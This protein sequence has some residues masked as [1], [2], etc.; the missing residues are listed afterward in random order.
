MKNKIFLLY[1][2]FI[3][4][5]SIGQYTIQG[6]IINASERSP[7]PY[8]NIGIPELGTGTVSGADGNFQLEAPSQKNQVRISAIGF[9]TKTLNVKTLLENPTI[10]LEPQVHEI[11]EIEI[12]SKKLGAEKL[13]G[14]KNKNR[15]KSVGFGNQQLGCELGSVIPIK[16]ETYLKSANFKLNHAKGDSLLFRV[17]IYEMEG[18]EI[19]K[20]LLLENVIISAPQKRG[21]LSVDLSLY[22]LIVNNDVLLA[23]EWIKDDNGKGNTGITFDTKKSKRSNVWMKRTSQ[24]PMKIS[25]IGGR[26]GLKKISLC[27][28]LMGKEVK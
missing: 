14:K 9:S 15:S 17:N 21:V 23:L 24:A 10:A 11:Q 28:W 12:S 7:I 22:E 19:G 26:Q 4:T 25:T 5:I 8:V 18:K 27:F 13:F 3:S 6:K 1:L 20:N 16:K 2:L